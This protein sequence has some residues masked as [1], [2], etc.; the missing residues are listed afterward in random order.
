MS[1]GSGQN[2]NRFA[3]LASDANPMP[4]QSGFGQQQNTSGNA[5][6]RQGSMPEAVDS[7]FRGPLRHMGCWAQICAYNAHTICVYRIS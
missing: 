2:Q 6:N 5:H 7:L 3:A 4:R 1:T